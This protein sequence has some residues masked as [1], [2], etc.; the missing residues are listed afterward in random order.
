MTTAL[1]IARERD[2]PFSPLHSFTEAARATTSGAQLRLIR[3]AAPRFRDDFRATGTPDSVA[4]YDLVTV[5]YPTAYGLFRAARSPLPYLAMSNRMLI[6]RWRDADGRRR[7]LLWEPSDVELARNVPFYADLARITPRLIEPLLATEHGTVLSQ[8]AAAGIAPEEVDYISFDHLHVQDC[9]RLLG[10][11][12]PVPG[13]S[14]AGALAAQLPNARMIVQRRE[15]D[16]LPELHPLQRPWYQP[17]TYRDLRPASLLVIDGD[18]QLGPG[19]ALLHTPGHSPGMQSLVLHTNTGVWASSENVVAA[20]CLTPAHS[21]IPGVARWARASG[22]E[23]ILNG[24]TIETTAEQYNSC[25]KE[26]LVV[27]PSRDDPR[28]LQFFPTSELTAW[29]ANPG[30]RP[31]F[32]HRGIS[33]AATPAAAAR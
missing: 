4:T 9:R 13:L 3:E 19:V 10:T 1:P 11:R 23:L 22:Q 25:V 16:S 20:E 28:F 24:N 2:L 8:L 6:V 27:D 32:V 30:A 17:E 7:T 15:L 14:P 31:T 5:P 18:V 29:W 12:G 21:R 26:K 33:H